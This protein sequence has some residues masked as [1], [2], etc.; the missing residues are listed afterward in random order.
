MTAPAP[1]VGRRRRLRDDRGSTAVEF[2]FGGGMLA[3][4]IILLLQAFAWGMGNLAAHTAANH[5]LQTSRVVGGNAA[6]GQND[7]T[8]LFDSLGGSFIDNPSATV[9][10]G[11]AI[12]TVTVRGRAHGLPFP[13]RVTVQAPTERYVR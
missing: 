11:A 12:T 1:N 8:T 3:S 13:I 6:A 7:A 4:L 2:A 5:A 10:R 9:S